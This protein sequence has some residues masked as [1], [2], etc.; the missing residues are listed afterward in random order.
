MKD[1]TL[2]GPDGRALFTHKEL[3]CRHCGK[4]K[5]APGF[6]E[7]LVATRLEFGRGMIVTSCCRCEFHNRAVGGHPSSL[8]VFDKPAH[9]TGGTCAIDVAYLGGAY[10]H[11][12]MKVALKRGWCVGI[13]FDAR[14]IHLDRRTDYGV[15]AVPTIF[16]Y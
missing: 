1:E 11:E 7:E 8:H 4:V 3:A 6:G 12:L 9:P 5:L 16:S 2:Y 13:N 15:A 14:F 10:A